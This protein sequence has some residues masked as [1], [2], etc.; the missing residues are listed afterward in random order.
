MEQRYVKVGRRTYSD[1]SVVR[2]VGLHSEISQDPEE[3]IRY[4]IRNELTDARN[5]GWSGPPFDPKD[6]ASTIGIPCEKSDKLFH[7]E[8]AELQPNPTKKERSIIKYNPN[9]PKTRQNFSIAHEIAHTFFPDYQH[10][11]KARHK[12]GKFDPNYEVEFLCDLG[13]SEIIMPTPDFDLDVENMG[14]SLK[15]LRVLSKRYEASREATA[16]RMIGTDF[17]P[18]ALIVLD[19]RHKPTEKDKIEESKCQ[20]NL[21][22]DYPWEPPSMKLRVQYS[23]RGTHF[24]AYIPKHKSIEE[25]SPLHEV[26]VTGKPFQ[27]DTVLN[28]TKTPLNTYVE[29]MALPKTHNTDL[30]SRVIAILSQTRK[31]S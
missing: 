23:V 8:D 27:G 29:A 6:F 24:S 16:I 14:I 19:Y 26:S 15:S 3:I 4:L 2:L 13:A 28:L 18:C 30:G 12:I 11:Y 5:Y 9:K 21:F 7:S 25:S 17:Y 31:N 20:L 10:Q 22:G 1:P